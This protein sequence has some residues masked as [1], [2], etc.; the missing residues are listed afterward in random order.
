MATFIP[1]LELNRAFYKDV[2]APLMAKH[3]PKLKYSAGLVGHGSDV[4]GFDNECSIDHDWG[5][6]THLFF[7]EKG[8]KK[9][10][11]EVDAMLKQNLPYTYKGFPVSFSYNPKKY[12]VHKPEHKSSGSV[13]HIFEFWTI[14]SYF[15]HYIK[16]DPYKRIKKKD[17]LIF[18]QQSLIEVT[19]GELYRDDLN[20]AKVREKFKYY[21]DDV[22]RYLYLIQWDKIANEESFM[23]RS[24]EV[25]DEL[26]S[27]IIAT[28]INQYII[29][30]CF[31]IEKKYMPYIKWMGSAFARLESAKYMYPLLL[32]VEQSKTWEEREKYLGKAYEHIAIMHNNLGFTEP[33]KTEVSAFNGRNYKVIQAHDV[34][35][36]IHKHINSTFLK[37]LKYKI[38]SVDQFI[39]HARINQ[40]KYIYTKFKPLIK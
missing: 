33:I 31:L 23:G 34:Y 24:G 9:T 36:V 12:L 29:Q 21:P 32:K 20:L 3:F 26:G 28:H 22:W 25:G 15:D 35:W 4:L 17:W 13:N 1:G 40:I 5:P 11:N 37:H 18:P 7:A 30:L 16:F 39:N 27:S 38:G 6:R 14:R 2:A 8:F 10:K 19:N